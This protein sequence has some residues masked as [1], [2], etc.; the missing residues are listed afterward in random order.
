MS[1]NGV[2]DIQQAP[3]LAAWQ[4]QLGNVEILDHFGTPF[5]SISGFGSIPEF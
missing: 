3:E 4:Q 1:R 5:V 2:G